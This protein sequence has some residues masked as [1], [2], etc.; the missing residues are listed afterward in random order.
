MNTLSDDT[1]NN[2]SDDIPINKKDILINNITDVIANRFYPFSVVLH[3]N[4]G[5]ESNRSNKN[6]NLFDK[7]INYFYPPHK[8]ENEFFKVEIKDNKFIYEIINDFEPESNLY[9]FLSGCKYYEFDIINNKF[10]TD[11]KI[12]YRHLLMLN[13]FA[14]FNLTFEFIKND[15]F[16][17]Y[18]QKIKS[19][20]LIFTEDELINLIE[21][22]YNKT[23]YKYDFT[24]SVWKA[25]PYDIELMK[26]NGY[27]QNHF[28]YK[29]SDKE[30]IN[31]IKNKEWST[32]DGYFSPSVKIFSLRAKNYSCLLDQKLYYININEI[33]LR[34]I[35][36]KLNPYGLLY[37][38]EGGIQF[39]HCAYTYWHKLLNNAI[40]TCNI[41]IHHRPYYELINSSYK[42]NAYYSN[43]I[44]IDELIIFAKILEKEG[45]YISYKIEGKKD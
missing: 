36:H 40:N 2:I 28:R 26:M 34:G 25:P 43:Y 8:Y 14:N 11:G 21:D 15:E 6:D 3:S 17:R 7:L 42:P 5:V 41:G 16:E 12:N 19:E 45:A 20:L 32:G 39:N 31:A 44:P 27:K 22:T 23:K 29:L 24:L 9:S 13:D 37:K 30:E 4:F 10:N 33:G 18:K 38:Y 35:E 1:T